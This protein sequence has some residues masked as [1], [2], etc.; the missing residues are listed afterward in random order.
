MAL[1]AK[2]L[3]V[4]ADLIRPRLAFRALQDL[5]MHIED[6]VRIVAPKD[7][8]A[9][10]FVETDLE[11]VGGERVDVTP[12]LALE[13]QRRRGRWVAA[14]DGYIVADSE[15][16]SSLLEDVGRLEVTVLY[17]PQKDEAG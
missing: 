10:E 2:A 13:L 16:L 17:V 11:T 8:G 7:D 5:K 12:D 4:G 14:R 15:S 1:V 3:N 9:D 6:G